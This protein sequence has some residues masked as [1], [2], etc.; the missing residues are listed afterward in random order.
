SDEQ[1]RGIA[2]IGSAVAEMDTTIQQNASMVSESSAAA[3][4]LQEQASKLATLMSV[5]RISDK[6]VARLQGSNTG[7]P[8]SGNKATARLPTLASRDNGND[9]WTT[10]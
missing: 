3:N 4:S 10:F 6:D 7:N 1:S 8:N 9:N 2:Q 5:F